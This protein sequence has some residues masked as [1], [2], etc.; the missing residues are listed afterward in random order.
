[1]GDVMTGPI[2][3]LRRLVVS[4]AGALVV[5]IGVVLI[6]LPGPGTLIVILGLGLLGTEFERPRRW[7]RSLRAGGRALLDRPRS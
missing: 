4:V 5:V 1:M 2:R 6:P 7:M 3:L